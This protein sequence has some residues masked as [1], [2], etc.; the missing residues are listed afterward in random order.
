MNQMPWHIRGGKLTRMAVSIRKGAIADVNL[1]T[2]R[3][4]H[5]IK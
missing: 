5:I 3:R 1:N 2:H 4:L